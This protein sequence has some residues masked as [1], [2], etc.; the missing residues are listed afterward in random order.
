MLDWGKAKQLESTQNLPHPQ[1]RPLSC[2][3]QIRGRTSRQSPAVT[4]SRDP[5]AWLQQRAIGRGRRRRAR[6]LVRDSNNRSTATCALGSWCYEAARGEHQQPASRS[7]IGGHHRHW[8]QPTSGSPCRLG[9]T[10]GRVSDATCV[11]AKPLKENE[12]NPGGEGPGGGQGAAVSVTS[13]LRSGGRLMERWRFSDT[14]LAARVRELCIVN[15]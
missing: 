9:I 14:P 4:P 7:E 11:F 10:S 2:N 8:R 6:I 13:Q 1:E 12:P 3:C 15:C 5:I